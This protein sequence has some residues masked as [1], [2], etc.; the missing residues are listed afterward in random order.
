MFVCMQ[1]ITNTTN[2]FYRTYALS[3]HYE[4]HREIRDYVSSPHHCLNNRS[5]Q[6]NRD[7]KREIKGTNVTNAISNMEKHYNNAKNVIESSVCLSERPSKK[8]HSS[9]GKNGKL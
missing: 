4:S 7:R 5:I 3:T 9:T 8:K 1:M 2:F 6:E